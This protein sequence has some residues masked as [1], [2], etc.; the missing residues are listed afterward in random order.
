[1]HKHKVLHIITNLPIGGAQDN[2]FITVERLDHNRYDVSLMAADDGEW[3]SRF[4]QVKDLKLIFVNNL[5][6]PINFI[7][8]IIAFYKIYQILKKNKYDIVHTHSSKPGFL[9]RIAAKLAGTPIII[10]TIHGFPFNSFM[11]WAVRWFFIFI[12]RFLSFISTKLITVSKLNLQHAINMKL[13]PPNKFVNI[14]SGID[15][16]KFDK[17]VDVSKKRSALNIADNLRIVGVV[18]R[19]TYCKGL[20]YFLEAAKIISQ[21]KEDVIFLMI[22]DG[23]L[24]LMCE[25]L[26]KKLDISNHVK[27][28]GFREDIP[29]LLKILD[30]YVLSSRWEGLGRSLTEAMY[31]ARPT[32]A[33]AVEGVPELVQNGKTGILVP[34]ANPQALADS[35]LFLLNNPENAKEMAS[36]ARE[37][38]RTHFSADKMVADIEKLYQNLI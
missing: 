2:T 17:K 31:L 29:E 14:Y 21:Q 8:D 27:M 28:L 5:T 13:A 32:V 37:F 11:P 20:E 26:I 25:D 35:I 19:L 18:G 24:R 6:R 34:P 33:T 38:V 23:E 15:F 36:N 16:D 9:G 3:V 10:H 1:L 22:G 12:E 7:N 30:V 4:Q